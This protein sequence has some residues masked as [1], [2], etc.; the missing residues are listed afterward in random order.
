[1][2]KHWQVTVIADEA[3]LDALAPGA[4]VA[5][6]GT[7][8]IVLKVEIDVAAERERLQKEF[9]RLSMEVTKCVAKLDNENFVA[10]AKPA[11]VEQERTRLAE[12]NDTLVKL[13]TQLARLN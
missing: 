9:D 13:G 12:F 8:K 3:E 1:M 10:R 6:V 7:D 4:P 11:V 5:I 2:C